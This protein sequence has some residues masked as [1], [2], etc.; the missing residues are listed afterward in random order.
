MVFSPNG[1]KSYRQVVLSVSLVL[2]FGTSC[3]LQDRPVNR[4]QSAGTPFAVRITELEERQFPLS[5]FKYVFEVKPAASD[6][7][8]EIIVATTDDDVPIPHEQVRF[9]NNH[10]AY[11]FMVDRYAVTTDGGRSWS[12][13]NAN[14]Q[15]SNVVQYPGQFYISKVLVNPDGSG[16]LMA[17]ARSADKRTHRFQTSDFGRTWV[18]N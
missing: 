3:G 13:W 14:D 18:L 2:L 12:T 1:F 17:A 7:W 8:K 15:A 9:I 11:V 6:R 4:W 16:S 10:T 5:K